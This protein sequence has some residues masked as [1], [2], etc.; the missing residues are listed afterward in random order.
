M[1]RPGKNFYAIQLPENQN[2]QILENA[3]QHLATEPD[4]VELKN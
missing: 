3:E 1:L 4:E 2:A